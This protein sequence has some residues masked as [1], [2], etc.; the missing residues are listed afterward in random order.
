MNKYIFK[1]DTQSLQTPRDEE[2][3]GILEPFVDFDTLL[4]MHY[5][6]VYHRRAIKIK[7]GMLSQVEL[8]DSDIRKFLP[9]EASPKSFLYEFVYNLELYGNA[10][11]EKAG[12]TNNYCLYNI[13]AVEWR[14]N[15]NREIFQLDKNG[16]KTQLEGYYLKYHSPSSRFYGEPDYLP[17]MLAILTNQEADNY[18]YAFFK[19]GA[20]PDLAIIHKNSEPSE[21]QISTYKEFFSDNFKGSLNAH[22]TLLTYANSA[23]GDRDA[24]IRFEKLG[25]VDDLSFENLKKVSRN[26]IAAAHGI[27]PR[28]LG[29]MEAGGLGGG[30]ELIGQLQQFNEIEIK[31]KIELIE[32]FFS[33]IGIKLSLK[34][35]DVTNFKDDGAIV[36]ELVSR[37]ILSIDEAR[38]I[39]GWQKNI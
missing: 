22:K 13:P 21:E 8:E 37:G 27:P 28:L 15:K 19:N 39:L 14:T 10:P 35:V 3:N 36:T 38:S 17:V 16:T 30:G 34:A 29:I 9:I 23:T 11:I 5:A 6:N 24:D 4:A 2:A 31:P 26:E 33:R 7:A 20:R 18:N 12:T 25:G 32:G 1:S